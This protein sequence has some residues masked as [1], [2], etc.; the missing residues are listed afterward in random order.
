MKVVKQPASAAPYPN[1][2]TFDITSK[3]YS[4]RLVR[5]KSCQYDHE[6]APQYRCRGRVVHMYMQVTKFDNEDK[7]E[8]ELGAM[9]ELLIDKG[10]QSDTCP[11]Y[12]DGI[13]CGFWVSPDELDNFRADYMTCKNELL[14]RLQE[15]ARE[16]ASTDTIAPIFEHD[17][18]FP[19]YIKGPFTGGIQF[20]GCE[21]QTL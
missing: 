21:G 15:I 20:H 17:D 6:E 9:E 11:D 5:A 2:R 18:I 8:H 7:V 16:E 13:S 19:R 10:W 3:P 1:G 12:P 4:F 14:G